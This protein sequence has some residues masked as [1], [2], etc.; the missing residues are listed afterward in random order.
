[1]TRRSPSE[2]FAA[3]RT[4]GLSV[5]AAVIST[6]IALAESG[7]DD[8]EAGDVSLETGDWGPSVGAWQIRT[9]KAQTGTGGDRDISALQGNL[10]R[11]AK[12]MA[13]ISSGGTYWQPWTVYD[14]G[15]YQQFLTP[16]QQAANS[17][18]A[19]QSQQQSGVT[20]SGGIVA[21]PA[22]DPLDPLNIGGLVTG[23]L[24]SAASAAV[25]PARNLLIKLAVAVLGLGLIGFGIARAVH[26]VQ[27]T[28][29]ELKGEMGN[30]ES[31]AG[32]LI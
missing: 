24:S 13:D 21:A 26:P 15:A 20:S 9:Q 4:A 2:L 1:M 16:A 31:A 19:V 29:G 27:R 14:T 22:V 32:A 3:A 17:S 23:A 10:A 18:G 11:Q 28:T 5:P 30:A 25:A 12:A 7:G 6:A 8:T